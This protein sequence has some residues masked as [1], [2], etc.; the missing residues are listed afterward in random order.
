LSDREEVKLTQVQF[1]EWQK[2]ATAQLNAL[3]RIAEVVVQLKDSQREALEFAS[4]DLTKWSAIQS[5]IISAGFASIVEAIAKL[6]TPLPQPQPKQV[7]VRFVFIVKDD[8]EPVNFSVALG[9]VTDA[10]GNTIPD[11]Q[12]N[13][14]VL[15][16]DDSVLSLSFDAAVRTGV[17][18]FGSP[19]VASLTAKVSSGDN[20][21]GSGAADFTVTTG[22]PAA[23]SN[24]A[25]SF[26]GLTEQ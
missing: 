12:V 23:I 15:S 21:L 22:D 26:E 19:G 5:D 13:L 18:S 7:E 17:V 11:A 10:E 2:L 8:H 25:L 1:Q 3:W 14:E 9:D 20:L 6:Q 4:T 24:V 16:S